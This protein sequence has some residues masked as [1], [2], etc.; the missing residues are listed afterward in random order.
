MR[1][2]RPSVWVCGVL[3]LGWIAFI[4]INSLQVGSASGEMSGGITR[5]VNGLL[6]SVIEGAEL[7]H[8]FIRKA[9]H[10]CEFALLSLLL[11]FDVTFACRLAGRDSVGKLWPLW[12]TLPCSVAVAAIDESIQLFVEGRV[13]AFTDVLIDSSGALAAL[14]VFFTVIALRIY[15]Q[16]RRSAAH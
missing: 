5:W 16:N 3:T 13:G 6:G 12:A 2:I 4:W 15:M 14:I 7:P 8:L 1:R 10:F 9:G 11:C